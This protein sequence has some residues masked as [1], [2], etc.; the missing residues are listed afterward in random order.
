MHLPPIFAQQG[1][2]RDSPT[3]MFQAIN[4]GDVNSLQEILKEQSGSLLNSFRT[5]S[6]ATVGHGR[7]PSTIAFIFCSPL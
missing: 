3:K 5:V 2:S 4:D 6:T 1:N 7:G